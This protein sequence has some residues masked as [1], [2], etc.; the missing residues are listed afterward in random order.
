MDCQE[1]QANIQ[2]YINHK[3]TREETKEF[4]EH[5]RQCPNCQD[6]LEINYIIT[7]GIQQLDQ[8]DI[9]YTDFQERLK[10]DILGRYD[11]IKKMEDRGHAMRVS[12]IAFLIALAMWLLG[13]G[14]SFFIG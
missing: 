3:L 11:K 9:S 7:T 4:I 5:I 10:E 1:V 8:D 2:N 13:Q 14:L 12:V 6:E